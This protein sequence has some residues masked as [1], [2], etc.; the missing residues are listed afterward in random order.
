MCKQTRNNPY[1]KTFSRGWNENYTLEKGTSENYKLATT[2]KKKKKIQNKW[3]PKIWPTTPVPL[4]SR[5]S[6]FLYPPFVSGSSI[7]TFVVDHHQ[8][9][10]R[11]ENSLAIFVACM[12]NIDIHRLFT[13]LFPVSPALCQHYGCSNHNIQSGTFPQ[14]FR[15][16][17]NNVLTPL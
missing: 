4:S 1:L 10:W 6:S 17:K 5:Q 12:S 11:S 15:R 2:A 7:G 9:N 3:Q 8:L 13:L 16:F 14:L